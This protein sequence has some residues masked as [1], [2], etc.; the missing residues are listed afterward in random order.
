MKVL[1]FTLIYHSLIVAHK[2]KVQTTSNGIEAFATIYM[3]CLYS[4]QL[5]DATMITLLLISS[6]CTLVCSPIDMSRMGVQGLRKLYCL[7]VHLLEW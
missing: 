5:L 2:M 7:K 4:E 1:H 3:Q 6:S